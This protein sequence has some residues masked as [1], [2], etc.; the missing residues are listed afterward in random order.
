VRFPPL[1]P[2]AVEKVLI[3]YYRTDGKVAREAADLSQGSIKRARELATSY[4]DKEKQ[5]AHD[6]VEHV[7]DQPES[8]VIGMAIACARSSSRDS[9]AL[10]LH[11]L[12]LAYRD[13][14]CVERGLFINRDKPTFIEAQIPRWKRSQL[15][16]ILEKISSARQGILHR[17]L[18]IEA[19]FVDLF[20]AIKRAGC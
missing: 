9:A 14:M 19:T 4:D 13:I 1:K 6:L 16:P 10:L 8:K 2:A 17:N 11:E 3:D 12:S 15:P 7:L 18:N 5:L 20:L